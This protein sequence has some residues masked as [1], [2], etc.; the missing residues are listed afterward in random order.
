MNIDILAELF[1]G[2]K[3]TNVSLD[4]EK[5]SWKDRCANDLE[6]FC[7]HYFPDVFTS[8]FCEFHTDVFQKIQEYLFNKDYKGLKKYMARTAPRGTGKSQIISMGLPLFC[9]CYKY[10]KN[11]LIVSDTA[12]QA[13]GFIADIKAELE[14]NELLIEDFGDLVAQGRK[15]WKNDKI[16][17]ANNVHCIGK[18]AGQKL[19]GIKYDNT[20]P[21]LII[22]DDL[23]NDEAV[24]T[25]GQR[26]KLFKW[27][28]KALLKCGY[29]DTIFVYIGTILHYEALLYKVI[30]DKEFAMWNRKNYRAVY[31]FSMS[32]HWETWEAIITDISIKD[33]AEEAYKFYQEH[34]E[35]MLDGVV[36]LWPQKEEDYYYNLMVE[37]V[38]DEDSFNSE[39]QNDPMTEESRTFKNEWI[40][41][42]IYTE[43]PE[44]TE[45]YGALDPSMG[46]QKGDTSAIVFLGRGID[47]YIYILEADICRRSPDK[48]IE[49]LMGYIIKYYDKLQGF[50]V[51]TNVMQ[52]YL[53]DNIKQKFLDVKMYVTWI[54]AKPISGDSKK[55]RI[56]SMVPK[57]KRGYVKFNRNHGM[58][59]SQLK[60]YPKG[61]DD[62]P[63]TLQMALSPMMG[64]GQ[65]NFGFSSINTDY[66]KSHKKS[67]EPKWYQRLIQRR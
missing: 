62:G 9:I 46:K 56:I 40:E 48:T 24:E 17:T 52:E 11:I 44:I 41:N 6:L 39:Q 20:R 47:N 30:N 32:K 37:K 60:N 35:E 4:S 64:I 22:I 50:V 7:K 65:S 43:L 55:L 59:L 23:E 42:N 14:E 2:A 61:H 19:R 27:F 58:L 25:Q 66:S 18:G 15:V 33:P 8:E 38:M 26:E 45:V 31:E 21:D 5:I 12:E 34:K 10:R 63:D 13:C 16:V 49:D 36:S 29:T 53:A 57:I 54:D 1:S 3:E 67:Q 28:M 51:E